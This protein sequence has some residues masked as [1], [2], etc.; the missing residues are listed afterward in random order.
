METTTF[1]GTDTATNSGT[2]SG[3]GESVLLSESSAPSFLP[4]AFPSALVALTASCED[5][6][7]PP[8]EHAVS[9]ATDASRGGQ[10]PQEPPAARAARGLGLTKKE[11]KYLRA[12]SDKLT[13][14]IMDRAASMANT[15]CGDITNAPIEIQ[16]AMNRIQKI[17]Q[18]LYPPLDRAQGDIGTEPEASIGDCTVVHGL[19]LALAAGLGLYYFV[20][21][22]RKQ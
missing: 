5:A 20:G 17:D 12:E 1:D 18:M 13:A 2:S 7:A 4:A 10:C 22:C 8:L 19:A 6:D 15:H 11:K 16:W 3:A 14:L 9:C 21:W